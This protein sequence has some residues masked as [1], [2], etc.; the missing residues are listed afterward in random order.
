MGAAR[1]LDSQIRRLAPRASLKRLPG[2]GLVHERIGRPATRAPALPPPAWAVRAPAWA[3]LVAFAAGTWGLHAGAHLLTDRP[4]GLAVIR[5]AAGLSLFALLVTRRRH[6]PFVLALAFVLGVAASLSFGRAPAEAA[7]FN[8]A[9]LGEALAAAWLVVRL[10]GRPT[11]RTLRGAQLLV[12]APPAAVGAVSAASHVLLSAGRA[13]FAEH[14]FWVFW[15]GTS[16]GIILMT[17]LL[18]AWAEPAPGAPGG[19]RVAAALTGLAAAFAGGIAV[20]RIP[21]VP[22]H[23]VVL[24]PPLLWAAVWLGPRGATAALALGA[25]AFVAVGQA[26]AGFGAGGPLETL[27][28]QIFLAVASAS[29]LAVAAVGEERRAAEGRRDL[30]ERR[31]EDASRFAAIGTLAAGV[32]HEI[33][34]PL[35][36]VVSNLAHVREQLEKRPELHGAQRADVL[37][38]L[39]DAE[40]GARRVRDVVL[41]LRAFARLEEAAGPVDPGRALRVAL[42]M[43]QDELRHRARV[44]TDLA[45]TPA[46]LASEPRLTQVFASLLVNAAQAIPEG[47]AERHEVR[48]V[49]F[50]RGAEVVAEISDTGAGM[51]AETRA[52]L[53]EPFFTTKAPGRG[54]GLGLA[55]SHSI[56]TGLGGRIEVE[57]TPGAGSRFRVVL[58][59]ARG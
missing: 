4:G 6:W 31:A 52:R 12:F 29:I 54:T 8:V 37:E 51:S 57:S 27:A 41:Q 53:F 50:P 56:V 36:Y 17:S 39:L 58:P 19:R 25:V 21:G 15:A 32:A 10:G 2:E 1:A 33:N 42:A 55:I 46:V 14:R 49:L 26:G 38:P 35:S 5:P 23:E 3:W 18:V 47:D 11:L 40:D 16:L 7:A 30:L 48:V 22:S 34:N 43:A 20:L 59:A 45:L 24:L 9:H 44:A 28:A 13:S